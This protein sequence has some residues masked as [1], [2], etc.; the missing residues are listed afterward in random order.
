MMK[1]FD[2]MANKIAKATEPMKRCF[3]IPVGWKQNIE[4]LRSGCIVEGGIPIVG[5]LA[6]G[7][8][9]GILGLVISLLQTV[10]NLLV[11]VLKGLPVVG[12]V[13]GGH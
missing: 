11:P 4:F 8:I 5:G 12:G 13:V 7:P 6:A 2:A 10:L 1:T 9:G 3:L